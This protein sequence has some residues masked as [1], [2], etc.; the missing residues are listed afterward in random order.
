MTTQS[1][2]NEGEQ[3]GCR[4]RLQAGSREA[5]GDGHLPPPGARAILPLMRCPLSV[6]CVWLMMLSGVAAAPLT[7][8]IF[9]AR[10]GAPVAAR[11]YVRDADGRWHL[12]RSAA[13]GG[14]AVPYSVERPTTGSVEVHTTVSAHP[15]VADVPPGRVTVRAER[16]IEYLPAETT[17]DLAPSGG[18]VT[19]RL[20]RWSKPQA[21][22]WFSGD[23]FLHRP[24]SECANL[25][26][27]EDINVLFPIHYWTTESGVPP[28]PGNRTKPGGDPS[29][30][31]EVVDGTHVIWPVNTEVELFTVGGRPHMQGAFWVFGHRGPLEAPV[32][33]L[34][35][36]ARQ[37][38]AQGGSVDTEKPN[39]PWTA[40][41]VPVLKPRYFRILN[42]HHWRTRFGSGGWKP[43]DAPAWMGCERESNGD[44]TEDGW[45]QFGLKFYY[46]LLNAG[47]RM[48]PTAGTGS[49]VHPVP[50]GFSRT[51]VHLPGGFSYDAWMDGLRDGRC[52]VTNGPS[53]RVTVEGHPPGHVFQEFEESEVR[54]RYEAAAAAGVNRIELIQNGEVVATVAGAADEPVGELRATV[55][56]SGWLAV[57]AWELTPD[58]R[59]RLAHTAPVWFEVPD[60]PEIPKAVETAWLMERVEEERAR[61]D[62][63]LPA[64]ALADYDSALAI[65]REIHARAR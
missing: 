52:F 18:D 12:V 44:L 16:G 22:Q 38:E 51:Y 4:Q 39:W 31:L 64:D 56:R 42:N 5:R 15:F 32:P 50:A 19:L 65:Y 62:G 17:V 34:G 57:R 36:I 7:G 14:S 21:H 46:A 23:V 20:A 49:G 27:A 40:A 54:V 6:P 1:H 3:N 11:L 33:P 55:T 9:D 48:I 43:V 8:R 30:E 37:I 10:T 61:H 45:T 60:F 26:L 25:S 24:R 63:V 41:M 47:F 29:P 35:P 13:E 28:S 59:Q 53:L 2:Q 58:S